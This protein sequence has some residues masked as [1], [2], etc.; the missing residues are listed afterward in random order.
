M[1][2]LPVKE[3]Q[4]HLQAYVNSLELW[5]ALKKQI[6]DP[7]AKEALGLL[8]DDGQEALHSLASYLRRRGGAPG[9]CELD[10]GGRARIRE[11]LAT[12]SLGDQLF[13]V[14][15]NLA[16]VV[17][18]YETY[19]PAVQSDPVPRDLLGSLS[20]QARRMLEGWDQHIDEMG[21]VK[22]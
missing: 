7:H 19:L 20:A 12:R 5:R 15:R 13:A 9:A 22:G 2:E 8:I 1:A 4:A 17:T 21:G 6:D 14:R 10:H 3:L 16:D 18:W 11:V